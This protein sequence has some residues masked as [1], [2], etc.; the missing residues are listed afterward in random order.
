MK[1]KIRTENNKIVKLLENLYK[2]NLLNNKEIAKYTTDS[3]VFIIKDRVLKLTA[4]ECLYVYDA[5]NQNCLYTFSDIEN[6]MFYAKIINASLIQA[7]IEHNDKEVFISILQSLGLCDMFNNVFNLSESA[8]KSF[9]SSGRLKIYPVQK[10][11]IKH[12]RSTANGGYYQFFFEPD[13][14]DSI[15]I[16]MS[17]SVKH[18]DIFDLRVPEEKERAILKLNSLLGRN[19]I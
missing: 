3:N 13:K 2:I 8:M 15:G 17:D 6:E 4:Y 19:E 11:I 16:S 10:I 18:V 14:F 12:F 5:K 7:I 9:I 1:Y